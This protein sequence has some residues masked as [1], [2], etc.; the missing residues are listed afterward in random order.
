MINGVGVARKPVINSKNE[1]NPYKEDHAL[2]DPINLNL[3][4]VLMSTTIATKLFVIIARY[5]F[6]KLQRQ[7]SIA[8]YL[9]DLLIVNGMLTGVFIKANFMYFSDENRCALVEDGL[10]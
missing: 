6:Y 5:L 1:Y 8:A 10:I 4:Y 9:I 7:E 2:C 3:W